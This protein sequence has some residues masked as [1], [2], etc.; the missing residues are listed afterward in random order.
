MLNKKIIKTLA[1]NALL[2]FIVVFT[3]T[4]KICW[5]IED[6]QKRKEFGKFECMRL[7]TN[8]LS[9]T[10]LFTYTCLGIIFP[11]HFLAWQIAGILFELLQLTLDKLDTKTKHTILNIIGGRFTVQPEHNP[12]DVWLHGPY[13]TQHWW[14]PKITDVF[15]NI[16]GF[17]IGQMIISLF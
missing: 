1:I 7:V 4:A 13:T 8:G 2:L 14:H 17:L 16:V 12:I 10:H 9:I 15:M 6:P 3:V 11:K 5:Y